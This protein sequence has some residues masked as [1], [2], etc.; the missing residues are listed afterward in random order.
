MVHGNTKVKFIC[1]V[2]IPVQV[3]LAH[4]IDI[5]GRV[6]DQDY[7][8]NIGAIIYNHSDTPF[9]VSRGVRIAQLICEKIYYPTLEEVTLLDST[10]RCAGG[11]GSIG[12]N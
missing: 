7:R 12:K 11:F 10:E 8:G 2:R 4:N 9:I 6:I 3:S 1:Y 5:G